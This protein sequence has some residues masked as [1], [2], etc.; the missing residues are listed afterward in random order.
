MDYQDVLFTSKVYEKA[1]VW[2][3]L[4]FSSFLI[5]GNNNGKCMDSVLFLP[6]IKNAT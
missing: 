5:D 2:F 4:G 6:S 1:T 3:T